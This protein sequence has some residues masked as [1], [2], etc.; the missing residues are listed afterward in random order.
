MT[1][2]LVCIGLSHAPKFLFTFKFKQDI[3]ILVIYLILL[4]DTAILNI[5][6]PDTTHSP[7]LLIKICH[8]SNAKPVFLCLGNYSD[9][10]SHTF[11][12]TCIG[13]NSL[14][15]HIQSEFGKRSGFFWAKHRNCSV[16][17]V[18]PRVKGTWPLQMTI[19]QKRIHVLPSSLNWSHSSAQ[20]QINP[21]SSTAPPR[22][23]SVLCG[24]TEK[25][26][27]RCVP[28]CSPQSFQQGTE[29]EKSCSLPK[30]WQLKVCFS[31]FH[32]SSLGIYVFLS[33]GTCSSSLP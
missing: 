10:S 5:Y 19:F 15:K 33:Y 28:F 26:A 12:M 25:A 1:S 31:S 18:S 2:H 14:N 11:G 9:I 3:S 27:S 22:A 23:P 17:C 16:P 29:T 4:Y 6:T 30:Y 13:N 8:Y 24:G 7:L 32:F 20:T 21:G